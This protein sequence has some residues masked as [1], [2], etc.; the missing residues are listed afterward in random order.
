MYYET[1]ISVYAVTVI[2]RENK[3]KKNQMKCGNGNTLELLCSVHKY[4]MRF[5]VQQHPSLSTT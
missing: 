2:K 3:R 5:C 4:F 1:H